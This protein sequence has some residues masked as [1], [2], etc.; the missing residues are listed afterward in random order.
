MT[1]AIRG[2][3]HV[4]VYVSSWAEAEP[5]Y[6]QVLGFTRAE[7]YAEWAVEGGPLTLRN[8]DDTA[9]LALFESADAAPASTI[10]FGVS[11]QQFLQWLQHLDTQGVPV[12]VADHDLAWSIYFSDP[13]A[14]LHEIT[15]YEH[16]IVARA[17]AGHSAA[18]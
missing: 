8:A 3:D 4:H 9:H 13:F 5:W 7:E 18:D 1:P 16:A 10:A 2:I 11:G 14:N 12:R 17:R 15:T 6:R